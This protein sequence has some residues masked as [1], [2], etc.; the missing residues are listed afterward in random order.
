MKKSVLGV[1]FFICNAFVFGIK[2]QK[3][4]ILLIVAEDMSLDLGCYGN[5]Y[6]NTPNLDRLATEGTRFSNAYTTYSVSSPSRGSIFTGLYPH[7]NGQIGLATHRYEMFEHIKTLPVYMKELG[8]RT[9]CFG[10]I[11]VNPESAIPFDVWEIRSSNFQKKNLEQYAIKAKTF[12]DKSDQ[13]FFIMVN[14]PDSHF[15][16]QTQVEGR[17]AHLVDST[18]VDKGLS[19]VG[20]N[21]E[22]IRENTTNYYNCVNRLDESVGMLL[23]AIKESGK[24]DNTII[25]FLS[26]H[27][28]QF[29]R[30]KHSNYEAGLKV[31]FMIK[32]KGHIPTNSVREEL[33]SV[34]DLLPS[35]IELTGG[36]PPANMPGRSL[37]DL[38]KKEK[39]PW[40]TYL[41]AGGMGSFPEVH[42]PRRSVRD[43]R[44]KL[45]LTVNH[46]KENP[47]FRF[48]SQGIGH[49]FAGTTVEEILHSPDFVQQGY[50][51]WRLPPEYELYDLKNDPD[52]WHNLADNPKYAKEVDRLKLVLDQWRE[53]SGDMIRNRSL[54]ERI[55][56]EMEETFN[57]KEIRNYQ[58]DSTF[59]FEYIDYLNPKK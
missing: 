30:G 33:V 29:S 51:I 45:I 22:R 27:G 20:A 55:N 21:S 48:Y 42:F 2:A 38:F 52:E 37:L 53:E 32:W 8:Y 58:K 57:N 6:V 18:S 23:E 54:L 12:A 34:I 19:F 13:P 41:F 11:H 1:S 40:R 14:F 17:P 50:R 3:P 5:P 26:D 16:F 49:F 10:K 25:F 24:L 28:A 7:Q 44:F 46:G 59:R 9:A 56:K 36:T 47:H 4:N 39:K 43:E 15:P 31:P 35:F